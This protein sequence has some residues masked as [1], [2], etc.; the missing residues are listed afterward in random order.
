MTISLI[1]LWMPILV[2]AVFA[3]IAS[4]LIHMLIKYHNSDY[5]RLENED[6]VMNAV[7]KDAPSPGLYHFP[8]CADM[9]EMAD[10]AMQQKMNSKAAQTKKGA[11]MQQ[12]KMSTKAKTNAKQLQGQ[13]QAM[14]GR[15]P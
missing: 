10:E 14:A 2:G 9:S 12:Q 1:Q 13:M 3:W 8:Y 6:D 7:G 5:Q 15:W 4:G 11:V